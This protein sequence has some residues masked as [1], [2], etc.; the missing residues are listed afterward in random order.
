MSEK[1]WS[2]KIGPI[3]AS[4]LPFGADF[5]MRQAVQRAFYEL[6]GE[7]AEVHYSGWGAKFDDAELAHLEEKRARAAKAT[8]APAQGSPQETDKVES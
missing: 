1:I 3:D 6:T 7:H 2:C 5:P 4:K 8:V